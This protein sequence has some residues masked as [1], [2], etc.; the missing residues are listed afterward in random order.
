VRH[1]IATGYLES[2][3]SA[4]YVGFAL[5]AWISDNIT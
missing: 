5:E 3:E 1:L 2:G 4:A